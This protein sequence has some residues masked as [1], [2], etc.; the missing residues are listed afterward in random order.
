MGTLNLI[1]LKGLLNLVQQ[2]NQGL[3][4]AFKKGSIGVFMI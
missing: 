4:V 1:K 3:K 2:S